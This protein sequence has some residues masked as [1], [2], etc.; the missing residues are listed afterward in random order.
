MPEMI[1]KV[2]DLVNFRREKKLNFSIGMD[3]GISAKNIPVLAKEGVDVVGVASAI[4]S[5]KD[6][7]VAL[8]ELKELTNA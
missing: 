1:E 3:G 5:K 6:P 4:F 2:K 7:T 8:K